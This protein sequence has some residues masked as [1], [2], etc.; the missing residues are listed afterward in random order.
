MQQ[1]SNKAV[2][3]LLVLAIIISVGGTMLNF[4]RITKLTQAPAITGFAT[5]S[6][7]KVNVTIAAVSSITLADSL[8]DFGSCS[9]NSTGTNVSSNDST[10]WGAPGVCSGSASPP[11]NITVQNDGNKNINVTVKTNT[12]AGSAFIGGTNPQFYFITRNASARPGCFNITSAWLPESD[13]SGTTGMQLNWKSFAAADTE[14]L[15]CANLTFTDANDQF[16]LFARLFLPA[17]APVAG[18]QNVT[19]TFT[20][21]NW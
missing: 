17:D 11:D 21:T 4:Y 1:I 5:T 15:A 2:T 10:S 8:I 13:F 3:Y 16:S 20:A 19:L 18:Q 6:T 7:G 14:Y 9:P 12:V